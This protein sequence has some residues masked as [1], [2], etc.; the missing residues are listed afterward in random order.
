MSLVLAV[1]VVVTFGFTVDRLGL[2]DHTREV[3]ARA[4]EC[5]QVL[6]DASL[7]DR[8]KERAL[9]DHARGLFR[10]MGVLVGGSAVAILLPLGVVWLL[11]EAGLWSLGAVL[12]VL[13]RP[14]FL[15]ATAVIGLV[16]F[17]VARRIGKA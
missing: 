16:L 10:L 3:V 1:M 14:D 17:V 6:R 7:S 12:D 9:R 13:E 15:G 8:E 11:D 2:V 4:R 5:L